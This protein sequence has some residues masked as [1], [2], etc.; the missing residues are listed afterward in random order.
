M[1]S[2]STR[3]HFANNAIAN[4]LLISSVPVA[5]YVSGE[6]WLS[7]VIYSQVVGVTAKEHYWY[8]IIII[9]LTLSLEPFNL[10]DHL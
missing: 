2:A 7:A 3:E 5:Y 9:L 1:I 4:L 10:W 6:I 8:A